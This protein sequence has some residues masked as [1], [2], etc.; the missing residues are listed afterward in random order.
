MRKPAICTTLAPL[1]LGLLFLPWDVHASSE[2]VTVTLGGDV[3]VGRYSGRELKLHGGEDPFQD[4]SELLKRGDLTVV[5]LESP[6]SDTDPAFFTRVKK[7]PKR[8]VR[9]RIP[10][11]YTGLLKKHGIDLAILAN[12]HAEDCGLKGVADTVD[13]LEA[14][15]VEHVGAA[16]KGNPF[17][18]RHLHV[19]GHKVIVWALT[20]Y[21][22]VGSPKPGRFL[23]VAYRPFRQILKELPMELANMR[24]TH[25]DAL[26]MV[27]LHWGKEWSERPSPGQIRLARKLVDHGAHLIMG[28]HPHVLQPMEVY[29]GAA[30]FYSLGNLTF[31]MHAI[32]G[33]RS[34]VTTSRFVKKN[35]AWQVTQVEAHPVL[36][37]GKRFGPR[38]ASETEAKT[39]LKTVQRAS[40]RRFNTIF[41]WEAGSLV[42][43]NQPLTP[44]RD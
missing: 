11:R 17:E 31:D 43:R 38:P 34:A 12:N 4:I 6:I 42:W 24:A 15:S 8:S 27:S 14:K 40:T 29:K 35:G 44:R 2:S 5:N 3:M 41:T 33:R 16:G 18:P 21:R 39:I 22:N 13:A 1:L 32:E 28:H 37:R 26:L 25:P 9:F 19:N 20:I 23:P 36:L 30:I 10:T 7:L